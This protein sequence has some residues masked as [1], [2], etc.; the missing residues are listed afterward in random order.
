[1][2][3]LQSVQ[4]LPSSLPQFLEAATPTS[5]GTVTGLEHLVHCVSIIHPPTQTASE[6]EQLST[7]TVGSVLQSISETKG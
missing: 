5:S 3:S 2:G 4:Y 7:L 6:L 1:M